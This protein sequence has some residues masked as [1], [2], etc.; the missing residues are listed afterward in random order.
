MRLWRISRYLGLS[1]VGGTYADSR[2]HHAPRHVLFAGE[3]PALA[4][5]EVLA[6]LQVDLAQM[7]TNLRLIA[8]D[9]KPRASIALA[10]PMPSGW[11]AN[12]PTTQTLG[13]AWLDA[14]KSLLLKIPSAILPHACN[15]MINP[16]HKQARTHLKAIDQ[17][18]FWIDPRLAR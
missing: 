12:I 16:Q 14:Q 11:Q 6:H 1:G 10:P 18:P 3:H 8:I 9:L 2:W 5:L 15:Y 13:D 7:P 4:M 17:G